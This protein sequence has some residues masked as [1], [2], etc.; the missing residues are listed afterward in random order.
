M[1]VLLIAAN[2]ER[3][4][5]PVLPLG[6]GC[7]AR[8]VQEAGHEIE[9]LNLMA[10]ADVQNV[11]QASIR[12]FEP[13]AVGI[14]V[15][16]ID[17]QEMTAP[18]FLLEPVRAIVSFCRSL[19]AVPI[20]IGGAGYSI[21]PQSALDYLGADMGIQGNGERSFVLLL[22]RLQKGADP[23]GIPGLHLY[24][25][26]PAA[27]PNVQKDPGDFAMPVPGV[28]LSAPADLQDQPIW[29][30]YQTR[31]GCPLRCSYCSTP[32]IEGALLRKRDPARVVDSL[33]EYA[34]A[35]FD[36]FFF[37]DNVFNLPLAY[38]KRIC[39]QILK[40]ELKIKWRCILYPWKVDEEL[41]R[42]MAL[43]GCEDVSLGFESGS[44]RII[45]N[46]NKRYSP[47]EV[48]HI[49]SLLQ[50]YGIQTMGFLL[51]G[52]PGEDR[53]TVMESLAFADSLPVA[54]MRITVGIR[55][56]PFT[57]IAGQAVK[58]GMIRAD[59]DLLFPRFYIAE[60]LKIWTR[61]TVSGWIK[62]RRNWFM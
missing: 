26:S 22:E 51:L 37:V 8:A 4:N 5:M 6:L 57:P 12:N 30:P 20:I 60:D 14:S 47:E 3:F 18:K 7:I 15:R 40:R 42:M 25:K 62:G 13:Q 61:E 36:R 9:L 17:D 50:K 1:H 49:C 48:R 21:F 58:D 31:R 46:M 53:H 39:A 38:A 32:A 52:G 29:L 34:A 45:K 59:D 41:V 44:A 11:I 2:T 19:T 27:E 28:H 35:G 23:A 16:N 56:Y 54:S 55:V 10:H 43:A 24:G 33:D